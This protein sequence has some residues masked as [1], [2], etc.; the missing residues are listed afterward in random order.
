VKT[1]RKSRYKFPKHLRTTPREWRQV[2]RQQW[3]QVLNALD[4]FYT[5]SAYT[6][7]GHD[8]H[9]L[10]QLATRIGADLRGDWISW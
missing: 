3:K 10:K 7:V 4:T 5:G 9:D 1:R 8:L 6:P 2:K